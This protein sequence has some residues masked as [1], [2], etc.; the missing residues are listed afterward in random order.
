MR[1]YQYHD[2]DHKEWFGVEHDD[3]TC[4]DGFET[5]RDAEAADASYDL[6]DQL[7]SLQQH[8]KRQWHCPCGHL[9]A[10]E[11]ETAKQN[12]LRGG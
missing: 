1:I 10:E 5:W 7:R 11:H 12:Y 9:S 3:G 4:E 2:K 6:R 8:L